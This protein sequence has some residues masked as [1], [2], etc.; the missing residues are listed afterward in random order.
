[1]SWWPALTPSYSMA[2]LFLFSLPLLPSPEEC[3]A[4]SFLQCCTLAFSACSL[5]STCVHAWQPCAEPPPPAAPLGCSLRDHYHQSAHS[6]ESSDRHRAPSAP[7]PQPNHSNKT[8]PL[9]DKQTFP[10]AYTRSPTLP[11]TEQNRG[12]G[13]EDKGVSAEE[14]LG[15]VSS[16]AAHPLL[17]PRRPLLHGLPQALHPALG[18]EP[19]GCVLVEEQAVDVALLAH[20][21]PLH[22]ALPA[23][24]G[25]E[26]G[27]ERS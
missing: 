6:Y 3:N 15:A 9:P 27:R 7:S 13:E 11:H 20:G 22:A 21:R 1:M 4:L 25:E 19:L 5:P 10:H 8:K 16:D 24:A 17:G 2:S 12:D 14:A 23:L 18:V 26:H